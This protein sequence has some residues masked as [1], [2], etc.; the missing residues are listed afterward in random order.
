MLGVEN[1]GLKMPVSPP[2]PKT[3]PLNALRAFEAAARHNSI[4]AAA[5]ELNVTPAAV[6]QQIESLEALTGAQLF[7]RN[8]RGVELTP[9][10]SSVA[11]DFTAAF[12]SLGMA[13]QKLRSNAKPLEIKIAA[14]P[15]I[16][17]MWLS[18]R[19]PDIRRALP[20]I[21][22]SV[23]AEEQPPNLVRA[24]YDMALFFDSTQP[25]TT[26]IRLEQDRITPVCSPDIAKKL[27]SVHDLAKEA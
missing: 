21:S 9:L 19:L 25:S 23:A 18:P 2:R 12:D 16:A 1:L 14:L 27:T 26:R 17:Q 24:P 7:D 15:S 13:S 5:I 3:P 4:T 10:G 22:I 6:A 20:D 11:E 8:P